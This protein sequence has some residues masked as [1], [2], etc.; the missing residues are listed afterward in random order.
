MLLVEHKVREI[1]PLVNWV[2]AGKGETFISGIKL[3]EEQKDVRVEKGFELLNEGLM[4]LGMGGGL[5]VKGAN[6]GTKVPKINLGNKIKVDKG[7]GKVEFMFGS[8]GTQVT[9]KTVWK[10]KGSQARIYVENPNPRQRPG[11]IH[12]QDANGTKYLFDP[13]K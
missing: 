9:S 11:Q 12:Y 5:K 6:L 13:Q 7:A 1:S 8:K 10:Q 4:G 2:E 3:T